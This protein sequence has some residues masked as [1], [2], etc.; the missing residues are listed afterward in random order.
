MW[1]LLGEEE[2]QRPW[3]LGGRTPGLVRHLGRLSVLAYVAASIVWTT[4]WVGGLA[5]VQDVPPFPEGVFNWHLALMPIAFAIVCE[6]ALAYRLPSYSRESRAAHK[7]H[8]ASLLA[9]AAL[10]GIA[11]VAAAFVGHIFRS[12]PIPSLYSTHSWLGLLA[13]AFFACNI[14]LGLWAFLWKAPNPG[15]RAALLP[16]HVSVLQ[17]LWPSPFFYSRLI[18]G[19]HNSKAGS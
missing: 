4:R 9:G 7:R 14:T 10:V 3:P 15:L 12:V 5:W 18:E 17:L 11:G 19:P 6:A 2:V 13:G 8:H 16:L 1:L